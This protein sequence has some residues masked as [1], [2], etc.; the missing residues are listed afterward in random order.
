MLKGEPSDDLCITRKY[1][2]GEWLGYKGGRDDIL[3]KQWA[4]GS[5]KCTDG[6]D[7]TIYKVVLDDD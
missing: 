3:P 5:I 6:D 1:S 7:D 2:N 4:G